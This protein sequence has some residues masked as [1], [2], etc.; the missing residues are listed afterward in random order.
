[1]RVLTRS[2]EGAV[3]RYCHLWV[4]W[5]SAEDFIKN[6][7]E[8]NPLK[9]DKGRTKSVQP[10][11]QVATANKLAQQ[12]TRLEPEFGLTPAARTRMIPK[13]LVT[14]RDDQIRAT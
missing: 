5:R 11:P 6:H 4:R 2:D 7:G 10:W 12:L 9:D 13:P 8:M 1:M 3:A 14:G